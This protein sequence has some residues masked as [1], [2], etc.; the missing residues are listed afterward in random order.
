MDL[1]K[2]TGLKATTPAGI[3]IYYNLE[4]DLYYA[5][6]KNNVFELDEIDFETNKFLVSFLNITKNE[7]QDFEEFTKAWSW[8]IDC[9][10][11]EHHKKMLELNNL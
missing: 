5:T 8:F 1:T 9:L 10:N 6:D 2:T 11:M 7:I 3:E 4:H